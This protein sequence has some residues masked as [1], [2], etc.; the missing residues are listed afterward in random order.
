[1]STSVKELMAAANAS[2]VVFDVPLLAE[3][4]HWRNRVERVLVI[5]CGEPTQFERVMQRPGWTRDAARQVI[6]SQSSR[7]QRR[8]IADAVIVNDA[9]DLAQLDAAVAAA[10][11]LWRPTEGGAGAVE[12]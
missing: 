10:W 7:T 9:I 4:K 6:A 3:S 5:D 2:V 12:Q 1:M 11:R 8:S